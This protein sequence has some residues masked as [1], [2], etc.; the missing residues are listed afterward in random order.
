LGFATHCADR[1]PPDPRRSPRG[2]G[3]PPR[4]LRTG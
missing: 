3:G 4:S 1:A 2:A